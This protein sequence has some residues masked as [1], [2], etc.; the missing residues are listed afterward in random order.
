MYR[1]DIQSVVA[2]NQVFQFRRIITAKPSQ[3]TIYDSAPR[4]HIAT[5]R[6]YGDQPRN[7]A[8]AEPLLLISH[9]Q[10]YLVSNVRK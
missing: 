2:T 1:K 9:Y 3:D 4:R 6:G 10:Q 8:T 7:S 5:P